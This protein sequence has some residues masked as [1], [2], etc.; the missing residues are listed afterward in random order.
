MRL[1]T[2][3]ESGDFGVSDLASK[4][5]VS[6]KTIYK[7][8]G[9][10]DQERVQELEE[11]SR[12]PHTQA[13]AVAEEVMEAIRENKADSCRIVILQAAVQAEAF[14]RSLVRSNT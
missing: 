7:W 4:Y 12:A 2:D 6:R 5:A 14:L 3:Y 13:R 1:I 9:R 10:F 8:L 11:R